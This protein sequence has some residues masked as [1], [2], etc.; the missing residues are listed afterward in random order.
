[1]CRRISLVI[2]IGLFLLPLSLWLW[3]IPHAVQ[4][5]ELEIQ[6]GRL[7]VQADRIPLHDLLQ[8]VSDFG[9]KVRIDPA[10]NPPI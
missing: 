6:N 1:M 5:F 3:Q 10:I 7:N 4:A 2:H 9:I 8:R